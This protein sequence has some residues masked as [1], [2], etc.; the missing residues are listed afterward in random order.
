MFTTII[1]LVSS[2]PESQPESRP[3]SLDIRILKLLNAGEQSK[4]G[5]SAALG[6][7]DLNQS[8][9]GH[10]SEQKRI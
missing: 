8:K 4:V 7:Y 9:I 5:I 6:P 1:P 3:E 2:Q 10:D